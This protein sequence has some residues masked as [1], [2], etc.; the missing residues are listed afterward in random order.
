MKVFCVEH[1]IEGN[2]VKYNSNSGFVSELH[3]LTPHAFSHFTFEKSRHQ[4]IVVDIQ[5]VG[6][7]YTDP[8]MHTMD[9]SEY[10]DAN[11][12]A[13]GMA[14]FFSSHLCSPLC[15]ALGL[16]QFDLSPEELSRL[17]SNKWSIVSSETVVSPSITGSSDITKLNSTDILPLSTTTESVSEAYQRIKLLYELNPLPHPPLISEDSYHSLESPIITPEEFQLDLKCGGDEETNV[18]TNTE[19]SCDKKSRRSS[20]VKQEIQLA[21][22]IKQVKEAL[23]SLGQVHYEMSV[24]HSIGRFTDYKPDIESGMHHLKKAAQCGVTKA[25]YLLGCIYQ[26]LP[27]QQLEQFTVEA[28]PTNKCLGFEYFLEAAENGLRVAMVIVAK[29]FE[30]GVGLG[31]LCDSNDGLAK[32]RTQDWKAAV[33]WYEKALETTPTPSCDLDESAPDEPEYSILAHLAQMY[34]IG[35][36]GLSI[37][38]QT[39]GD[40]YQKAADVAME[41][42]KGKLANKYYMLAEEAW[43]KIQ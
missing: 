32:Q 12:G 28:N 33:Q 38:F 15:F 4:L 19:K 24:Y 6:D 43:S 42:M 21:K 5:G 20:S 1:F 13:K 37:D 8:Q 22:D 39:A 30:T 29:T 3:R 40:Y 34:N 36:Y 10:G 35:G 27:H 18:Y 2:Y 9:L 41:M 14:L 17:S 31:L 11:L 7:L 16:T 25:L 23:H 26:Q